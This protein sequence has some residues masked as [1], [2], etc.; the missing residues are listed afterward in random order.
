MHARELVELAALVAI[1]A[2]RVVRGPRQL[3]PGSVEAYWI[4]SKCRFDRW[5]RSLKE[6]ARCAGEHGAGADGIALAGVVEEVLGGE[7]LTRVWTAAMCAYDRH[8]GTEFA[9]PVAR[10]VLVGHMEAR[11]RVLTLLVSGPAL[12]A[13]ESVR[14]NR[15]RHQ[16][17]RWSDVLLGCLA[18]WQDIGEFAVDA[19]RARDFADDLAQQGHEPGAEAVWPVMLASLHATFRQAL[20]APSPN[21]DLNAKIAA[22]IV[23]CLPPEL[24]TPIGTLDSLWLARIASL[25][26][27]TQ[28]LIDELLADSPA[29]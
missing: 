15:L 20:V 11:H 6:L 7:M 9:E 27:D 29:S 17:E 4:G 5:G 10:S 14:L 18:G 24:F 22:S 13:A 23:A 12:T 16:T 2:G 19:A 1:H 21:P 8:R 26:A 25:T 28:V 3:P